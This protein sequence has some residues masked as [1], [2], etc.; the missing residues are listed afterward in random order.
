MKK[1][2]LLKL[3]LS[4]K[5]NLYQG[6]SLT[7]LLVALVIG[8][9]VLTVGTAGFVNLLSADKET[10]S[11]SARLSTLTRAAS[12]IQ[13][14]IKGAVSVTQESGGNCDSDIDSDECLKLTYPNGANIDG[15]DCDQNP[16]VIYYG[17]QNITNN[18]T[19]EWNKPGVLR[20]K[21]FCETSTTPTWQPVADGL[22]S[23]N[24]D[25]PAPACNQDLPNWS[26]T[27]TTVYGDNGNG[28]GG[29]R[30][31]LGDPDLDGDIRLVR[32]F[33]Y[34]HIIGAGENNTVEV[35]TVGFAGNTDD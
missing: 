3:L 15:K 28:K 4:I 12:Y 9:I 7:E 1:A 24:E 33:L 23:I 31:C 20:R 32:V 6:L 19:T 21:V 27:N 2:E 30:F 26:S 11:K 5:A 14:D 16:P 18:S 25:N 34:G 35:S 10:D 22:I 29:F 13:N 8:S 17:Y